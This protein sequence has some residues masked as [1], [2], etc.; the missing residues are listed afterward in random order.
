M[1]R[2]SIAGSAAVV[3]LTAIGVTGCGGGGGGG[4]APA[5]APQA[6]VMEVKV[7]DDFGAAVP[8][9]SVTAS[10]QG[11]TSAVVASTD[12]QGKALL[13]A[14]W[15]GGAV[16]LDV[17]RVTFEDQSV[18][19]TV[20]TGQMNTV[21][22]VLR[23]A[24]APAG[25]ALAT[26]SGIPASASADGRQL[27][28]EI[29]VVVV[30]GAA[31]PVTDLTADA[32]V[33]KACT[34]DPADTR[35]DCLRSSGGD[36]AYTVLAGPPALAQIAGQPAQ[37][38]AAA[39]LIDQSGSIATS[40]PAGA[41]LYAAK[42][43][44]VNLGPSDQMLAGSFAGGAGAT[45]PTAPL[46]VY[47]PLL[48]AA[49]ARSIFPTLDA[50]AAQIGGQTPLYDAVDAMRAQLA[51]EPAIPADK[52]RALVVFT[53]GADTTCPSPADCA[54]RRATS[55]AAATAERMRLF[56]IGLS[57]DTD[58]E[59]LGEL[60]LQT[61]GA[62]LYAET[63]EQLLPLYGSVGRLISLALPTYRLRWTVES[64]AAGT[65]GPGQVLLGR[66][67]V[68]ARGKTFDVPFIVA[69]P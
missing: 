43:L 4:S 19:P 65:F 3:C 28:F 18:A 25:G 51:A 24:A 53:D 30:D 52:A 29:E 60:A 27:T 11:Q 2:P 13:A 64:A 45:I 23:R 47:S 48:D 50:L 42:S 44:L 8:N 31:E 33:L 69:V 56:T 15:P 67:Q 20:V 32:F 17:A 55:I 37:P 41:R 21:N 38:Y 46:T 1:K 35:A 39:L 36:R 62:M 61:G 12:A 7:T 6:I 57:T 26:R 22:V 16:S 59:A 10:M 63:A 68:S 9:A 34:P 54:A 14:T 49:Q 40:D 66:V 5:P 58:V